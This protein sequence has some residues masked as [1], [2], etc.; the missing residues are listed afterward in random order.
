MAAQLLKDRWCL[1]IESLTHGMISGLLDDLLQMQVI[2]QEEMDTVREE[3]H[4][5]A[6]KTRALLNSVI[7]KGDLASQIFIDSLCKKNPFVA[8]KLGLSAGG[9]GQSGNTQFVGQS[10]MIPAVATS[11]SVPQAL[12]APKTLTESHPDG[13]GEILKLCPSEEREK[14][15]KENEGEIYP[16]LVK[17]GRQ[18]QAL[19]ICNIKFEE[20]CER[21]GAELD[22]K[23]MKKL[24]EDLDYTVQVERNLSATEME[25]KLKMF[26]GRPEHKFSDSTFLVFMSHGILEGICGTKYKKQEPDVLSYSTIF[27]VFNNINCPGLKDKP[28]IIIVQACRG[29]N[30]GMAWVSDSL[31]PSATSSQEPEDLEN[32]AIHR[33]HVEKDLIAFCSSTPDHVSWRDPKTG[34]LFIVQLIKCFQN[35]AWNCDLESLFLKVQRHFE[36]PKQKLQM[37]TRERATLT[38]RFF[39]FPGH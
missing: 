16:V 22:I 39:L 38:K 20:L 9:Q 5:P 17:A 24:L 4:R 3:H 23:G 35:H 14:L 31:G 33:T 7:P 26:A 34:S 28:K 8:A 12:Q 29:E 13:S 11:C 37:P 15:Q 2:N 30:E 21:V 19:I 6:E 18:R 25:S 36:T 10:Q 27:R 32:D 1:I